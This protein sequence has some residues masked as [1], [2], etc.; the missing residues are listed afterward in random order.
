MKIQ[1]FIISALTAILSFGQSRAAEDYTQTEIYQT[2]REQMHHAF[3]NG[4]SAAFFSNV[5]DLEEF[6]LQQDDLHAYYTQRC[7][8]IVFL[9]NRQNIFEAYKRARQLSQELREKKLDKEMYMSIN[10]MGHIYRYCG[11]KESARQCFHEVLRRMNEAG[12]RESMPPIY[13]NLVNLESS[14]NPE[15]ALRLLNEGLEIAKETSPERVFDIETRRSLFYYNLGDTARFLE[16]YKAYKD[17]EAEGLSSVHGRSMEIAYLALQGKTDEAVEKARTELDSDAGSTIIGIYEKAGR[18]QDAYNTMKE[19]TA[20]ANSLN[21]VILSNSMQGIQ[22]EYKLYEAERKADRTRIVTL[23]IVSILLLLLVGALIYIA[24]SRRRHMKQLQR[25][26]QHAL[27]SDNMKSAFIQNVSHE[28]RTPLN[29]ISGFAQVFANPGMNL[30]QK[31]RQNMANMMLKNT[32]LITSLV[33]EMLELSHNESTGNA[34]KEDQVQLNSLLQ[35]LVSEFSEQA[36]PDTPLQLETAL[37][38]DFTLLTN[39]KMLSRI[40]S[41]LLSNAVKYTEK[42]HITLKADTADG[43][44]QLIV[45]DTG[46]GIPESEAEHVFERFVKL[47]TFKTGIGLGLPLCRALVR[48]LDGTVTLDTTYTD[49]ARF[50]V[51]LPQ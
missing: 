16:G 35:R 48:R 29:I 41:I 43:Q 22:S 44:L 18:W 15:E 14:L 19:E 1:Y 31:E 30:S 13:M 5:H 20:K 39:E 49:G 10:M 34:A 26:Y 12:Y 11:N 7:N 4:D 45:E 6:L 42:G 28:V 38:A 23:A 17:G 47:D 9:M 21:A 51:Q 3:N 24:L 50:I 8:E 46:C 36:N 25:A 40:V 37:D 33:D 27:E 32:S 2:L